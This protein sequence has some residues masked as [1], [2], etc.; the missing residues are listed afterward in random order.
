MLNDALI[1]YNK[2][3]EIKPQLALIADN[4]IIP[5][6]TVRQ[7]AREHSYSVRHVQMLCDTGKIPAVKL[8]RDWLILTKYIVKVTPKR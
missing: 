5:C 3:D 6:Q 7:Y 1:T 4:V 2:T 8:A